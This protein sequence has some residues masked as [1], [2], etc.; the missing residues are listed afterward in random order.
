MGD[1]LYRQTHLDLMWCYREIMTRILD[2][3]FDEALALCAQHVPLQKLKAHIHQLDRAI[4]AQAKQTTFAHLYRLAIDDGAYS[5]ALDWLG[6]YC[7]ELRNQNDC[8]A[9]LLE[10]DTRDICCIE[11]HLRQLHELLAVAKEI[12]AQLCLPSIELAYQ[13]ACNAYPFAGLLLSVL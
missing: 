5:S 1:S 4:Q 13:L 10:R 3:R 6:C 8:V 9:L 12:D 2:E 11:R 7:L